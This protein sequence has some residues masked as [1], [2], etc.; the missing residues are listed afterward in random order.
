MV[1]FCP[2]KKEGDIMTLEET[3]TAR[4]RVARIAAGFDTP[5]LAATTKLLGRTLRKYEQGSQPSARALR[6]ICRRYR[7]SSDW[8]LGLVK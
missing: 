2:R 8:L 6:L 3:T 7:C 5:E 4:L 1:H